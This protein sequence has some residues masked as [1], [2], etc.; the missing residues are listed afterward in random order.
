[1]EEQL[2]IDFTRHHLEE[3]QRVNWLMRLPL[4]DREFKTLLACDQLAD[5]VDFGTRD[6][7]TPFGSV[8][9]DPPLDVVA[10]R[11][12]QH[13]NT[14]R[15]ALKDLNE[16]PWA[17]YASGVD[18]PGMIVI[19]WPAIRASA[20]GAGEGYQVEQGGVPPS[21]GRG[22][23]TDRQGYHNKTSGLP[24]TG[25]YQGGYQGPHDHENHISSSH[26]QIHEGV[27]TPPTPEAAP[28]SR[29]WPEPIT[30]ELLRDVPLALERLWPHAVLAYHVPDSEQDKLGFV[31]ACFAAA[32][33]GKVP[34]KLLTDLVKRK[35][36]GH[37]GEGGIAE[38]YFDDAKTALRPKRKAAT[39]DL[40]QQP[41]DGSPDGL[42][43]EAAQLLIA[44]EACR[45]AGKLKQAEQ[46]ERAA[47]V[48][49]HRADTIAASMR[50]AGA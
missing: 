49:E 5:V 3:R 26:D 24:E 47:R 1:M 31:A 50:E 29:W 23:R 40:S 41:A 10:E 43:R 33:R 17:E 15:R 2:A 22:T 18:R 28:P 39:S 21:Q 30:K 7:A 6:M 8:I 4:K 14:V 9:L 25:G 35:A 46:R 19:N 34:G 16:T 38:R 13:R 27:G 32:H 11:S 48:L 20:E 36:W 45:E 44:A 12:G 37:R 42:R